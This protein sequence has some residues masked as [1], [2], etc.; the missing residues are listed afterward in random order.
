MWAVYAEGIAQYF[1][2]HVD[3]EE[4]KVLQQVLKRMLTAVCEEENSDF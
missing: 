2:C 1:A 3:D 4:V